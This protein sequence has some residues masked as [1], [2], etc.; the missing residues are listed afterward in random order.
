MRVDLRGAE[1]SVAQ[2]FFY[3]IQISPFIEQAGCKRVPKH[4]R[5]SFALG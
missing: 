2:Q 5:T 1:V 4:M 3:S